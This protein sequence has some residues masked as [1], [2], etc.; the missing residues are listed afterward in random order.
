M[1]PWLSF[2]DLNTCQGFRSEHHQSVLVHYFTCASVLD[3]HF[4]SGQEMSLAHI[5]DQP[6]VWDFDHI[7]TL[8]LCRML[9]SKFI[10]LH[11][12]VESQSTKSLVANNFNHRTS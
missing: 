7:Q 3:P 8:T 1:I 2:F 10:Q 9:A 12:L 6:L 5:G 11:C 4:V